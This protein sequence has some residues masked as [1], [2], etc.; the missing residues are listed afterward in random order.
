MSAQSAQVA[1]RVFEVTSVDHSQRDVSL[2][3]T[4]FNEARSRYV[5]SPLNGASGNNA[6]AAK[7]T[8]TFL[9]RQTVP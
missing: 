9:T 2:C 7:R 5:D 8:L 4:H 1:Y 3:G 6:S